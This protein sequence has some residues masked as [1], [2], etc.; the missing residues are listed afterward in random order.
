L[1]TIVLCG[2]LH[3]LVAHEAF[4]LLLVSLLIPGQILTLIVV[5]VVVVEALS[6]LLH[7]LPLG[8]LPLLDS[9]GVGANAL[10]VTSLISIVGAAAAP[11]W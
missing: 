1:I 10:L 6:L 9:I 2:L 4:L 11:T 5:H 3:V 7:L 8:G